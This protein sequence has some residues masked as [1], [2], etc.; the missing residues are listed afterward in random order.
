MGSPPPDAR[1]VYERYLACCNGHRVEELRELVS[2]HV[3][4]SGPVDGLDAYLDGVRAVLTAFPDYHW[5]LQDLVVEGEMVAARLVGRG[6]HTGPFGSIA[7]TGR[8][9]SS[10]EL[11]MY[12]ITEGRIVSCWGDLFPVVRDALLRPDES[13]Q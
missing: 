8:T 1:A 4:G 12:R 9:V 6:T 7:P 10:Q 5:A 3:S 11:V 13:M 2:E